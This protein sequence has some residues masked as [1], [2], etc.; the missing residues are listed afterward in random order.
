MTLNDNN[1]KKT[2]NNLDQP[3][4]QSCQ[5]HGTGTRDAWKEVGTALYSLS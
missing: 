4:P 2:I 5:L 3:H 1:T